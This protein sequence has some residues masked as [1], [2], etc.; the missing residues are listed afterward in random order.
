[1]KI[2]M[3]LTNY[4]AAGRWM[5]YILSALTVLLPL[6]GRTIY[7]APDGNANWSGS[8]AAPSADRSDGPLSTLEAARDKL[9]H[10]RVGNPH[11][12]FEVQLRGG[13]YTLEK[14][15]VLS[16]ID[17]GSEEQPVVYSAYPGE[18][19]VISGGTIVR[20]WQKTQ[21]RFWRAVL[22]VPVPRTMVPRQL[23]IGGNRAIRARTPNGGFWRIP[24]SS[25]IEHNFK[26]P[27]MKGQI[28]A[29]WANSE[30][31]V[32]VLLNWTLFRH[33]FIA[34][35]VVQNIATLAGDAGSL[36]PV[37]SR[38]KL[39]QP[40]QTE[41]ARYHIENVREALDDEAEW[42]YD[43]GAGELLYWPK[44]SED[45]GK[46]EV[47]VTRI[48]TLVQLTGNSAAN[49]FVRYVTFRGLSFAYTNWDAGIGGF[50]DQPQAAVLVP[51]AFEAE[52]V[53]NC[54][55][56]QCTF[57]QLGG[58]AV[59]FLGGGKANR[60]VGN[61]ISDTGAGGIKLGVFN[62]EP[63]VYR[64]EENSDNYITD[65]HIHHIGEV[66]PSGVGILIGQSGNNTIAHNLIHDTYYSAISVGWTWGYELNP[67]RNNIIE[68]NELFNILR[69][70]LDDGG[71]IYTLG[72]SRGSVIRNNVI[73][74][75]EPSHKRGRG[76][77]L[78]EGTSD[79]LVEDNIV[80]RVRSAAFHV[81]YGRN[82]VVRNNIFAL[83]DEF[84]ITRPRVEL[85]QHLLTFEHNIVYFQAGRLLGRGDAAQG[86]RF[87]HNLYFDV[88]GVPLRFI[89]DSFAEW[90][91]RGQ[92]ADS[93]ISDPM[94]TNSALGDFTLPAD[95]PAN[96]IGFKP[97]D[98]STVGPRHSPLGVTRN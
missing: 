33:R 39:P 78:D 3:L 81:H 27:F 66:F 83:S 89:K 44:A 42:Y 35:D 7:V 92:D 16:P 43:E 90:Q 30:A 47:V 24:G 91:A 11:E 63:Q 77:Y 54:E 12:I 14:P 59:S 80:Y 22:P 75:V 40:F 13:L 48:M 6:P 4:S 73:H 36:P 15:F 84:Q 51:A 10:L 58:Y 23:F 82:N 64:L 31:E 45:M 28:P 34:V 97:I 1:M 79:M 53:Q 86:L 93:V 85:N 29:H 76:I 20:G 26:L 25:S 18:K 17:S 38:T 94:F 32:V 55:V 72:P 95:S 69:G 49:E 96:R 56:V 68:Y 57:S 67:A 87:N 50:T 46:D 62:N 70:R 9:R 98:I 60:I 19:P 88:R 21:G 41:D 2:L 74:D 71:G 8:L 65:N 52:G 61:T 5:F 37:I